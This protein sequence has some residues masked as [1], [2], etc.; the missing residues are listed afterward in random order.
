MPG[1]GT[2]RRAGEMSRRR[3]L[4]ASGA[5]AVLGAP[6]PFLGRLA[7][8]LAPIAFAQEA[9]GPATNNSEKPGL[10]VLN[11]RPLN[12]ETPPHL[13]DD[14]VTPAARM[15]VRNNGLEPVVSADDVANWRLML[16][17]E[18][19]RPLSLSIDELK[20]DFE[21]VTLRLQI[22]CAG[23]GRRFMKPA[24]R[25]N[26]WSFGAVSC[27]E[28]TGVRLRDLLARAGVKDSAVYTA[29]YGA[30]IHLSGDPD[31]PALSRGVPIA[32]ALEPHTLIAFSMNG[33]AIP[34]QNG[35]PLRLVAPGWPGSCSQKWL[36]RIT[37][38]D[39]VHDGQGMTGQSY[40]TP[41]F[42]VPPGADV[43]DEQMAIIESLPVKSLI[44]A[45]E[46]GAKVKAGAAFELRGHAWAGESAV[47]SVDISYDFGAT[48]RSAKLAAPANKYAWQR[49]RA[50]VLLP[51]RGYYELWARAADTE[52]RAQ[53]PT[54]PGWNPRGYLNNMQHRIAVFAL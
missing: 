37:I 24:A 49:W 22:E 12:M 21:V 47:S 33:S 50:D 7:P 28:W 19:E 9:S 38:R 34:L 10:T 13:L 23:N 54:P 4:M 46:T 32:K 25:G 44:T 51:M 16:D 26:Q 42:P 48:W 20:R 18:V 17:G 30:D 52:G 53:P 31:K 39:V 14:E 35:H 43:P 5:G 40:R 27:A 36:T 3:L 29:H 11:D 8:S 6:I 45:P 2:E 1:D 15:F 41:A